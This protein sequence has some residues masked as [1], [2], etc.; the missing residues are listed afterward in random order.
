MF[1]EFANMFRQIYQSESPLVVLTI[2]ITSQKTT[3]AEVDV[4]RTEQATPLWEATKDN[5]GRA[6]E[7]Q[8]WSSRMKT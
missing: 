4:L 2:G 5:F 3:P 6:A 8:P 1:S 7:S